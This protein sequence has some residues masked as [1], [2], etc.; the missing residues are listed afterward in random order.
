MNLRQLKYFVKVVE[1]GNMTRAA[2]ELHVAQPALGMQI[3]Q[4]EEDLG[5]ALLTR[6]SRGVEATPAGILLHQRALAILR[7]VDDARRDVIAAGGNEAESIR[8]GL[9]PTLM[10]VLGA[11]VA[12]AARERL[13][14]VFLSLS[15]AMSHVLAEALLR[16]DV[17]MAIAYD[18]PD[19]PQVDRVALLDEELVFVTLPV[20]GA[21]ATVP[22]GEAIEE[23]LILPEQG[24]TVRDHVAR[25][26]HAIG[27]APKVAFEVRS[28]PAMKSLILRGAGSGILPY[29]AVLPEVREGR[30]FARRIVAPALRRT[31]Y[32]AVRSSRTP[33][34]NEVALR[35]V[36]RDSL[37]GL[38]ETL[39]PLAHPL[40]A[41]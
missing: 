18:V 7:T 1:S 41:G 38:L 8:L 15:E 34:R 2:S 39:G 32:V 29:G 4:L 27:V 24:D 35:A 14:H 16:G 31:L 9:T 28:I 40:A 10:L 5:V 12:V 37:S 30:L 21:A 20:A 23:S 19:V 33:L 25:A 17:D 3:R 26:A 36:I 13:P 22:F 11:E 6:H